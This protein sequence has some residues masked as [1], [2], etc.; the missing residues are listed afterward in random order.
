VKR[1]STQRWLQAMIT[2]PR[3]VKDLDWSLPSAPLAWSTIELVDD[4]SRETRIDSF[5][6]RPAACG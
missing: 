1:I 5:A 2:T 3:G 6:R 4:V